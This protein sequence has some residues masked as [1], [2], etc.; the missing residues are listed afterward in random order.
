MDKARALPRQH[1]AHLKLDDGV[2]TKLAQMP[3]CVFVAGNGSRV[4]RPDVPREVVIAFNKPSGQ[5]VELSDVL[6]ATAKDPT[7]GSYALELHSIRQDLAP[8]LE[9]LQH[10]AA[11]DLAEQTARLGCVP[12]TGFMVVHAL[13]SSRCSVRIDGL[14]LDPTIARPS[15][16]P[17]RKP[18]PQM[19]HNWLGERR[20]CLHRWQSARPNGWIWPL[21]SRPADSGLAQVGGP[22]AVPYGSVL[23]ELFEAR[24]TGCL[25]P[26]SKLAEFEVEPSQGLLRGDVA[27][28]QLEAC[29]YLPR[30][31]RDTENWWLFDHEA[32]ALVNRLAEKLR[33]AQTQTFRRA[34]QGAA[35]AAERAMP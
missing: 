4:L 1:G 17:L 30:G 12:S 21:T 25:G 26:L 28:R 22:P 11:T 27:T 18:M 2:R 5:D 7:T 32:S 14:G 31:Q 33:F 16:L 9:R 15:D 23:S 10:N 24:R 6:A 35:Q 19:F 34:L 29:F 20:L 3:A 8:W 13:W